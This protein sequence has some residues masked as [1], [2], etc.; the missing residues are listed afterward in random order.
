MADPVEELATARSTYLSDHLAGSL[1]ALELLDHMMGRAAPHDRQFLQ[2][3]REEIEQDR[4][5][6][7]TLMDRVGAEQS[8]LRQAGA[9]VGEKAG[10]LE[11]MLDDAPRGRLERLEALEMLALGIHGKLLLWRALANARIPA[12]ATVDFTRLQHRAMEQQNRV[13]AERLVVA[14]GVLAEPDA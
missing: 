1:S 2:M 13:E 4:G 11:L 6:L 5:T 7:Q 8:G 9:W 10:R 12:F 14:A 3:L